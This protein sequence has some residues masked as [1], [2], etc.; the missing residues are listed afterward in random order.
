MSRKNRQN[1][2]GTDVVQSWVTTHDPDPPTRLES[3]IRP[4]LASIV[5]LTEARA[6][7]PDPHVTS[8]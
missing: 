2:G 7:A 4:N 8:G 6:S 5:D 3:T 1:R